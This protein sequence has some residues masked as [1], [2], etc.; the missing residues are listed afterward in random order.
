M[1]KSEAEDEILIKDLLQ[2]ME[3][4][5]ADY[6]NTFRALTLGQDD[7]TDLFSNPDF[8]NWTD[9]WQRRLSRQSESKDKIITLMKSRNPAVIPR[10]HR[11]EQALDAAVNDD[12]SLLNKL[13]HVLSAPYGYTPEQEEYSILPAP[14]FCYKT[15]CGT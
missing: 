7:K 10:N 12:L 11:V 2:L 6:T 3:R 15:F 14:T 5:Q 9:R 8:Q 13:L 1:C 4:Y